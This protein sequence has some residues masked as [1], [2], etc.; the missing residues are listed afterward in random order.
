MAFDGL[1]IHYLTTE[2]R[3]TLLNVRIKKIRQPQADIFTL[4]FHKQQERYIRFSLNP[5]FPHVR[6]TDQDLPLDEKSNLLSA[7]KKHLE[8]ALITDITQHQKDRVMIFHFSKFDQIFGYS[9][10]KLIFETMGR[11]TN[12]ILI[13]N[14]TI[15][16]A[17]YKQFSPEH[18]SILVGSQF[19]FFHTDKI[20]LINQND[21]SLLTAPSPKAI[22]DQF[23][24]FSL[25][26]ATYLFNHKGINIYQQQIKPT[27]YQQEK[28]VFSAFDIGLEKPIY[29][30]SLSSLLEQLDQKMI[31][32]D[33]SLTQIIEKELK[34]LSLKQ[35]NLQ[36]DLDLNSNYDTYK[37]QA[38]YIYMSGI[39]LSTKTSQLN[40]LKLVSQ[41]TLNENAQSLY[42]KYHRAKKAIEPIKGQ[43]VLT[44]ALILYYQSLLDTLSYADKGDIKDLQDELIERGLIKAQK[45]K[46]KNNKPQKPT[47][48]SFVTNDFAIYIGKSSIQNDYLTHPFSQKTD[49]W[50]HVQQGPG[51]HVLLRGTF[52]EQSLRLC[53]MLA[54]YFSP[55]R[56]SSSIA[57]DYTL[58]KYIKKIKGLPGYNVS[59]DHQKTM[60]IDIDLEILQ[61]NLPTYP[62]LRK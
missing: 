56:E 35:L 11:V 18:R 2:L 4:S 9:Y 51:A 36:T 48:L 6:I 5:S 58:I 3:E 1:F 38:D 45:T 28:K 37:A 26:S 15:I 41:K 61:A 29:F 12:L 33:K 25:Q 55:M 24:G 23:M 42:H 40:D 60:Y 30:D 52:N 7:L 49:Y 44:Q 31:I 20:E 43:L 59:Y 32:K 46:Q 22:M 21:A 8:N 14:D 50:F 27:L 53:A 19:E 10:Y 16:D 17:Y 47:I 34:R 62:F 39:D 54:A 13:Q 57:V